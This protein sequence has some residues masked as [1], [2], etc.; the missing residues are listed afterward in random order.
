VRLLV[1][2]LVVAAPALASADP[3]V[4]PSPISGQPAQ[5]ELPTGWRAEAGPAVADGPV[6]VVR[7]PGGALGAVSVAMAPNPDAWRDQT[8]DA[9]VDG[10]VEGFDAQPGVR[11]KKRTLSKVG[12]VPCLDLELR[13]D[14]KRVAV[15][16]LLFRTRTIAL[17]IEG[18]SS[19]SLLVP[20]P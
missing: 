19:A 12:I 18:A 1:A 11:V 6:L 15:R 3:T 2:A 10:I 17:V 7:G 9:N 20:T 14:G 16:L 4:I 13:R 8:R 5:L